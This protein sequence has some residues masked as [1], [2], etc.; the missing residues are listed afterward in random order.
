MIKEEQI[1]TLEGKRKYE[2]ELSYLVDVVRPQVTQEIKEAKEQG[3]LSENADYDAA[4][5]K[6]GEVEARIKFLQN[7]LQNAKI[8]TENE[9]DI[10][11]LGSKVKLLIMDENVE[12]EYFIVGP[13]EA[14]PEN[15]KIS[16]AC[17]LAQA[18]LGHRQGEVVTVKVDN[19]YQVEIIEIIKHN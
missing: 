19:P 12:E 9:S 11:S 6:Q 15:G 13:A 18:I 7:L 3:D 2:E 4:R 10:I 17:K 8:I 14:D 1:L 16:N 5:N